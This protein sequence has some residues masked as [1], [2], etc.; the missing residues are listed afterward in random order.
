MR[1]SHADEALVETARSLQSGSIERLGPRERNRTSEDAG[2][3]AALKRLNLHAMSD[4]EIAVWRENA[5][6][7]AILGSCRLSLPSVWSGIRHW[8][9][10]IGKSVCIAGR[11]VS[12]GLFVRRCT[13][14]CARTCGWLLALRAL[15]LA[16][17]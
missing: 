9:A 17:Y 7:D 16:A 14:Q 13:A 6:I 11:R 3:R 10:F 1:S 2:P 8:M 5:R 12:F 4:A 15:F